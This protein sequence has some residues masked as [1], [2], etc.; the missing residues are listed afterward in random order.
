MNRLILNRRVSRNLLQ[1]VTR[2][3]YTIK[4]IYF[5]FLGIDMLGLL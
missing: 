3:S 1:M 5:F 4:I 2:I